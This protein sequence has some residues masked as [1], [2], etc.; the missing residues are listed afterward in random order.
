M[1]KSH[2]KAKFGGE[3]DNLNALFNNYCNLKENKNI[4]HKDAFQ[5]FANA[6][7]CHML[8]E[9]RILFPLFEQKLGAYYIEITKDIKEEHVQLL[10]YLK[11][12]YAKIQKEETDTEQ[13]EQKLITT[14]FKHENKEETILH[15]EIVKHFSEEEIKRALQA[16]SEISSDIF[17]D[18]VH[19]GEHARLIHLFGN[20]KES[21]KSGLACASTALK[22]FADVLEKHILWEERVLFPVLQK[23][24]IDSHENEINLIRSQHIKILAYLKDLSVKVEKNINSEKEEDKLIAELINHEEYE[25]EVMH[26][27]IIKL[28]KETGKGELFDLINNS[29]E[30]YYD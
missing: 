7:H 15:P 22:D 27:I 16:A 24:K 20:Y 19:E 1:F 23:D 5:K 21:K 6:L 14:L 12:L 29:M 11:T 18:S 28:L 2:H 4:S 30:Q 3:H 25:D 26:P 10:N 17:K 13:D 9:E 8:W